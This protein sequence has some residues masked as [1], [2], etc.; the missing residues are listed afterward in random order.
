MNENVTETIA[1][2]TEGTTEVLTKTNL[3]SNPKVLI[4]GG[5]AVATAG[6]IAAIVILAKKGKIKWFK[7]AKKEVLEVDEYE[8]E[9]DDQEETEEQD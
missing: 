6:T 7:K 3:L 9:D 8:V 2:V 4:G 1:N 5:A